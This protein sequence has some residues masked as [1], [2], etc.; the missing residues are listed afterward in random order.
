MLSR[1][2]II[3]RYIFAFW[4]FFLSGTGMITGWPAT[5][6]GI[7]GTIELATA[8]RRYSPLV[9]LADHLADKYGLR[10]TIY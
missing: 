9:E 8:L 1:F 7:A 3:A 2:E 4:F 5:C 10:K 6:C